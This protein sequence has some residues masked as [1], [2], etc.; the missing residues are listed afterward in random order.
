M[1]LFYS[2]NRTIK[3]LV[4]LYYHD[5]DIIVG[6]MKNCHSL[7]QSLQIKGGSALMC[8]LYLSAVESNTDNGFGN[9]DFII[10]H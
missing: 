10:E 4:K 9:E 3:I 1:V 8:G 5:I 6:S 7:H 2:D